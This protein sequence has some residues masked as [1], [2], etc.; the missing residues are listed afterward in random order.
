MTKK[1]VA[2]I[3]NVQGT[4]MLTAKKIHVR[5]GNIVMDG[6][7]MGSMP[8]QFYISPLNLY[9]MYKMVDRKVI[10]AAISMLKKGKREYKAELEVQ[11]KQVK[12]E[13]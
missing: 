10:R 13:E 1:L 3:T 12:Q 11:E 5:E 2:D 8:G 4:P 9:K 6:N 7:I